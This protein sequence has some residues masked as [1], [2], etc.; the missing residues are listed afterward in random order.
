MYDQLM[1]GKEFNTI[2]NKYWF[3]RAVCTEFKQ[4]ECNNTLNE[5]DIGGGS[6]IIGTLN[7]LFD[8]I[9]TAKF[10]SPS[11]ILTLPNINDISNIVYNFLDSMDDVSV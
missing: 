3:T 9:L 8:S 11:T 7:V 1:L 2:H 5:I 6:M 10:T 4:A